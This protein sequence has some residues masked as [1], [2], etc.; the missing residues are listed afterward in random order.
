[1]STAT[2]IGLLAAGLILISQI[3]QVYKSYKSKQTKDLS[4]A[5]IGLL[6]SG[7]ILW[8]IY[9]LLRVDNIIILANTLMLVL[10][11]ILLTLKLKYK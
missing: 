11:L 6:I 3:P 2:L 4:L 7:S 10:L 8:L 9:G 1:M 5:M